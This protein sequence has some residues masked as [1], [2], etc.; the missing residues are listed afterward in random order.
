MRGA[1]GVVECSG[2]ACQGI[3]GAIDA[4]CNASGYPLIIKAI[5]DTVSW[6]HNNIPDNLAKNGLVLDPRG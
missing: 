3:S 4:S 6:Q 5:A 1:E 2:H